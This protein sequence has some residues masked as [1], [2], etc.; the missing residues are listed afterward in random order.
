R[1]TVSQ[2]VASVLG[3][4][5]PP[6]SLIQELFSRTEGNPLLLTELLHSLIMSHQ[7]FDDQGR[8]SP[9]MLKELG[10]DFG[11]LEVPKTLEDYCQ[12]KYQ[13]LP[14]ASQQILCAAALAK[15]PLDRALFV[16]M[17]METQRSDWEILQE[18]GLVSVDPTSGEVR[19]INPSFR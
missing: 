13:R 17:G 6:Q 7:I 11:K 16:R 8:W 2:Y 10:V 14:V 1:P 12:S 4:A 19:L 15:A 3:V 9:A 18:E 5:D